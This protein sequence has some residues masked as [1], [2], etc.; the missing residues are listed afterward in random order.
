VS[1]NETAELPTFFFDVALPDEYRD[2]IDGRAIA[3]G[4]DEGL[5]TADAVIAGARIAWNAERFAAATN[6]TVISRTGIGYDN[7]DVPAAAAVGVTVCNAPIAPSVST[8]EHTLALMLAITKQ[9]PVQMAR[10]RAG[11]ASTGRGEALELDGCTLGLVALGR[12][13][14]RVAVVAIALGMRVI[15]YDPFLSESPVPGVELVDLD[16]VFS[17]ADVVSLHAPATADTYHLVGADRL[18]QMKPGAYLINASR[19]TLIDQDALL[20]ALESGHLGGV[21]LDVTDPEPLPADHPLL[22]RDDVIITP[23]IASATVAG[24]RR[25]YEHA[26]DNALAVLEGRPA[27]VVAPPS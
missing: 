14:S 9:L 25:L 5:D 2:L 20:A 7:V 3:V 15:A 27:T 8:A 23:H 21:A 4:P 17:D 11:L 10:S 19:G 18:A 24:R 22:A 16:T 1:S 12:I 6:L 26:I 13:S